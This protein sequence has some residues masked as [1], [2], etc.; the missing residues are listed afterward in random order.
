[1]QNEPATDSL[2]LTRQFRTGNLRPSG[3]VVIL[4]SGIA[5]LTLLSLVSNILALRDIQ[6]SEKL[7]A[8]FSVDEE[9]SLATWWSTLTLAGLGL[10]TYG[11]A[12]YRKND[13]KLQRIAWRLLALGFVFLSMDEGCKLHERIGGLVSLEGTLEH[14]RWI[15]LWLPL[16]AVAAAVI[17]W[18]LWKS[19]PRVVVGLIIGSVVFLGGAVGVEAVNGIN[20]ARAEKETARLVEAGDTPS[21]PLDRSGKQNMTYVV[22]TAIEEC[23]EMLGV[24]VWYGVLF[25]AYLRVKDEAV[26]LPSHPSVEQKGY[27]IQELK[28]TQTPER[29]SATV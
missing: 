27:P 6:H 20:R 26:A 5:V 19:S 7:L 13:G 23:L 3:L 21:G 9:E 29:L 1:M 25:G 22:G 15:L 28:P 8:L 4:V 14:A 17:F 10:L 12:R 2:S 11:I 16:G 18:K 24:V